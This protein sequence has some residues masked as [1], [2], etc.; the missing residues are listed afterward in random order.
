MLKFKKIALGRA[1]L[2]IVEL[3]V[4]L[5]VSAFLFLVLA[6][7]TVDFEK[8]RVADSRNSDFVT[9]TQLVGLALNPFGPQNPSGQN[10]CDLTMANAVV[11]RP[12]GGGSLVFDPALA[13]NLITLRLGNG[14]GS[15]FLTAPTGPVGVP[16]QFGVWQIL[17]IQFVPKDCV[18]TVAGSTT[19]CVAAGAA[20]V[21]Q[22]EFFG[23]LQLTLE[24]P[25][26]QKNGVLEQKILT[27]PVKVFSQA[28]VA[29]AGGDNYT[30]VGCRLAASG[31]PPPAT[32]MTQTLCEALCFTGAA[33]TATTLSTCWNNPGPGQCNLNLQ[34]CDA[35]GLSASTTGC[36][37]MQMMQNFFRGSSNGCAAGQ[38]AIGFS[39]QTGIA[40]DK[41]FFC[42]N[43]S[44][45]PAAASCSNCAV[46]ADLGGTS[47]RSVAADDPL[48][49]TQGPSAQESS[50]A[51]ACRDQ[52]KTSAWVNY[53]GGTS[54]LTCGGP[55]G[56]L[57]FC[58]RPRSRC[59]N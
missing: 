27:T 3:L 59:S 14:P 18:A 19:N 28:P 38:F 12:T 33:A 31:A 56:D 46:R 54:V 4:A 17:G 16:R 57:Q 9:L 49:A 50:F 15:E 42:A 23:D 41:Q 13:A 47:V 24:S 5:A 22:T 39:N 30:L 11:F 40:G 20:P 45:L 53:Q 25:N 26:P 7:V 1:G 36:D 35:F 10:A 51:T 55:L 48:F 37:A 8:V 58:S 43:G 2:S 34:I 21:G 29:V 44:A 6:Q 52:K 32:N